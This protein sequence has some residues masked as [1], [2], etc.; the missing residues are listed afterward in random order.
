MS[1]VVARLKEDFAQLEQANNLNVRRTERSGK[2]HIVNFTD[3]QGKEV[4]AV[5]NEVSGRYLGESDRRTKELNELAAN[6]N[7][8]AE[9]IEEYGEV[10]SADATIEKIH[11]D[12]KHYP[13]VLLK[14]TKDEKEYYRVVKP[15]AGIYKE[16][17]SFN[18]L[19]KAQFCMAISTP[20]KAPK[21]LDDSII[22]ANLPLFF[23]E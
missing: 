19:L 22:K 4:F 6:E 16:Y 7:L 14:Y 20:G 2:V 17:A 18:G 8:L 15:G 5:I 23:A 1:Q 12:G 10:V 11:W 13:V 21:E 9:I 3:T